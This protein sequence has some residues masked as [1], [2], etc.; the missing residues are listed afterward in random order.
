MPLYTEF[1]S[2]CRMYSQCRIDPLTVWATADLVR[3]TL[4]IDAELQNRAPG[5]KPPIHRDIPEELI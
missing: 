2:L 1:E 5:P 3:L 4:L